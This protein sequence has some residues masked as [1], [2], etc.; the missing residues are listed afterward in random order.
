MADYGFRISKDSVDVKTGNDK[1]M[2]LTSKYSL[3]KGA[4]HG[5]GT[6]VLYSG[7]RTQKGSNNE[8]S[9][10]HNLNYIPF[11]QVWVK[12]SNSNLLLNDKWYPL[13]LPFVRTAGYYEAYY[14][15]SDT[16]KLYL[17]FYWQDDIDGGSNTVTYQ[18]FIFLDKGKL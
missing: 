16:T 10:T 7:D 11:I 9:V 3:L 17:D 15:Y 13:P 18:Y 6:K 4:L 14:H 1:D 5:S 2:V 8:L 12:F